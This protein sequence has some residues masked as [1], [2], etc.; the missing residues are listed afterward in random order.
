[1]AQ[2][3]KLL[4]FLA[5]PGDVRTERDYVEEVVKELNGGVASEKD[6][7]LQVVRWEDDAFPGYGMDAQALINAQIA[8]M[9]KYSLFIGIMWN[10]LG[11]ATPRAESGT[12]EEFERAVAAL[13][14]HSQPDIWFYFRQAPAK[15]DTEEQ[16]EQ[17]KK[18]LA[19]QKQIQAHGMP[20]SYKTP[21]DFRN[22]LRKQMVLW[23]NTRRLKPGG[24]CPVATIYNYPTGYYRQEEGKWIEYHNDRLYASFE[25][26]DQDSDYIYLVDKSRNRIDTSRSPPEVREF[27]VRLPVRGGDAQWSYSNPLSWTSMYRVKPADR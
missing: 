22:K 19:F 3:E 12:V 15:L 20:W 10:R 26:F 25:Q 14:Q 6:I 8:E 21:S 27:Y 13:T 17:R 2:V 4:V 1:M 7:I 16:L 18:V 9:A 23:L 5:S 11:T 24:K